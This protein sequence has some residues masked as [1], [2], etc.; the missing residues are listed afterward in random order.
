MVS[1]AGKEGSVEHEEDAQEREEREGRGGARRE[2]G[3]RVFFGLY[4]EINYYKQ[5]RRII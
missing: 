2:R 1:E 5:L 4:L 3:D